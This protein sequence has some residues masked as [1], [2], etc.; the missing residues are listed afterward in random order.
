MAVTTDKSWA[1]NHTQ[2]IQ[3][4]NEEGQ[5]RMIFH[6]TSRVNML[7]IRPLYFLYFLATILVSYEFKQFKS[8]SRKYYFWQ[9]SKPRSLPINHLPKINNKK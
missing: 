7:C 4:Q 2:Q 9:F 8:N 6:I 5:R 3:R 1:R